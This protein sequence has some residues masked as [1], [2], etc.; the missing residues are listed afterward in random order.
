MSQEQGWARSQ[1]GDRN[2]VQVFQMHMAG[3]QELKPHYCLNLLSLR[4]ALAG[5]WNWEWRWDSNPRPSDNGMVGI[6]RSIITSI[7]KPMPIAGMVGCC[8]VYQ[9]EFYRS[10][11]L[12]RETQRHSPQGM[13]IYGERRLPRASRRQQS[14]WRSQVTQTGLTCRLP[15][16][17]GH[18]KTRWWL[19]RIVL[20]SV[21]WF[22]CCSLSAIPSK[23]H[24]EG[25]AYQPSQLSISQSRKTD[26]GGKPTWSTGDAVEDLTG[27]TGQLPRRKNSLVPNF[28]R[29][30]AE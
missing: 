17:L 9:V 5:G 25:G 27:H 24:L 19:G 21:Y 28:H 6:P 29:A 23:I 15:F 20:H 7:P 22:R 10:S 2:A 18:P 30:A 11:R 16:S 1:P 3:T 4:C 8:C 12:A 14:A 26:I 13:E